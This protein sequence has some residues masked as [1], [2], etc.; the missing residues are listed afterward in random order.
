MGEYGELI[1]KSNEKLL[2]LYQNEKPCII[3]EYLYH[4]NNSWRD[5]DG[6]VDI[7]PDSMDIE[8][9]EN[10]QIDSNS[11]DGVFGLEKHLEDF[12][13]TNWEKTELG[14][15]FELI[16][17][18][19][20]LISQQ[21]DT[22]EVGIIDLLVKDK[23]SNQYVVIELK[24]NQTSDQTVGPVLRYMGWIKRRL[25][26]GNPV[27]GIIVSS[28][29]DLRLSY[30]ISMVNDIELIQFKVKFELIPWN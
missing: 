23:S 2:S 18:D 25:S 3:A 30:A 24:K 28:D 19:G 10:E 12:L 17:E 7:T 15:R 29:R 1:V 21:Y 11:I 14:K 13:I 5:D 6:I 27:K 16:S 4:A 22:K 20:S 26:N 9:A 8:K